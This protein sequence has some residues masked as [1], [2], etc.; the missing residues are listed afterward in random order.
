MMS[1]FDIL[2]AETLDEYL[3]GAATTNIK[4]SV[5]K[6]DAASKRAS[7]A[8]AKLQKLNPKLAAK[9]KAVSAQALA[10][11]AKL[12]KA[13]ANIAAPKP[14]P[15]A[16][17]SVT[18]RALPSRAAA[19]APPAAFR[20][21]AVGPGRHIGLSSVLV[22]N[23]TMV[24]PIVIQQMLEDAD[25][26]SQQAND[27]G[28]AAE[29]VAL[30]QP[31]LGP[32]Q[33]SNVSLFNSGNNI[34]VQANSIISAAA[35]AT[36]SSG[37]SDAGSALMDQAT[38]WVQQARAAAGSAATPVAGGQWVPGTNYP[39]GM[40]V[41]NGGST[42]RAVTA[43]RSGALPG[44]SGTAA[45]ITDGSVVWAY[46][47]PTTAAQGAAWAP[48]TPYTSGTTVTN[49][50]NAYRANTSGTSGAA[51]GPSGTS[52]SITDGS[53]LW[54][55]VSTAAPPVPVQGA[56]WL[57]NTAYAAGSTVLNYGNTYS[58][59]SSGTSG[60]APGPNST[61]PGTPIQDGT[62][63]WTFAN[64]QQQQGGGGSSGGGGGGGGD[65][66]GSADSGGG[67]DGGSQDG[68]S[69]GLDSY[70][71]DSQDDGSSDD[72]SS[73]DSSSDD[74]SSDDGSQ[75]DGSQ[76]DQGAAL[77][78]QSS[79]VGS[80]FDC[81]GAYDIGHGGGGGG[82]GGGGHGGHGGFGGRG[83]NA[84]GG[85]WWGFPWSDDG[86][87]YGD[88]SDEEVKHL[89]KAVAAEVRK[90]GSTIV[91]AY[92]IAASQ[93]QMNTLKQVTVAI[94]RAMVKRGVQVANET[95]AAAQDQSLP[96][97]TS[98]KNT[99][100]HLQWHVNALASLTDPTAPYDSSDDLKK[101]VMQSF[102]DAN[103][104]E[105]G[106]QRQTEIWNDMWT[107]IGTELAH[108]PAKAVAAVVALPGK[109]LGIP[110][111]VFWTGGALLVGVV[112]FGIWKI[113]LAATPVV[114]KAV[115]NRYLP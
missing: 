105:E 27:A 21:A 37:V 100:A 7:N 57:P 112:G 94:G 83:R 46:V 106:G 91:G 45:T 61:T 99:L 1:G 41:T 110:S 5:D 65:S 88:A 44:P 90:Y 89:A 72:G 9:I 66:G 92:D 4:P 43:G 113:A 80:G 8:A 11:K 26:F 3:V 13:A 115:V 114:T 28:I 78:A 40:T 93:R 103:A 2:G 108:M 25:G 29:A 69:S 49:S 51:P 109:I 67:D 58:A 50:G 107:D 102:I 79:D 64:A 12:Q 20:R 19:A 14:K 10:K 68:G 77:V 104:V 59:T 54:S 18:S 95:I 31:L 60:V 87:Y 34:I 74:S 48:N 97:I 73:D 85:T 24:S 98:L 32:L 84:W 76:D 39:V 86:E 33:T 63:V 53:V 81:L 96:G 75:D 42:Y 52:A 15:K 55:Y 30:V 22:T 82:H 47:S 38:T 101:W 62:V 17:P 36:A 56:Q 6:L 70:G 71:T 16:L 35:S 111:W 23:A